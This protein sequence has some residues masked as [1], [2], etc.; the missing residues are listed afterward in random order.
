MAASAPAIAALVVTLASY[1]PSW[2]S[3][4]SSFELGGFLISFAS[5]SIPAAYVFG[6][7]PAF[8][9]AC[10]YCLLLTVWPGL[11]VRV[12]WRGLSGLVSAVTIGIPWSY[13]VLVPPVWFYAIV[14]AGTPGPV[15]ALR[16]PKPSSAAL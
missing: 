16:W 3:K 12:I 10:L 6:I 8:A 1:I 14:A 11:R 13:F 4:P 5:I 2:F 7:V 15:L 9:G